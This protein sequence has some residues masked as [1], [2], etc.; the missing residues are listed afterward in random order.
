MC[1]NITMDKKFLEHYNTELRYI[2]EMSGE[3]AKQNPKIAKR[4]ILDEF[5]CKDP[6]VERLLEGFAY[7]TARIQH[8]ID[9]E[10]S[11]FS[12]SLINTIYPQYYNPSPSCAIV[13]FYPDY[14]KSLKLNK[15]VIKAGSLLKSN[16]AGTDGQ[17]CKFRTTSDVVLYPI[18][19]DSLK[20]NI[21]GVEEERLISAKIKATIELRIKS[22][23]GVKLNQTGLDSLRF[24]IRAS[25]L[26]TATM[27]YEQFLANCSGIIFQ[28]P[29]GKRR[30]AEIGTAFVQKHLK[31]VG[32]EEEESLFPI[33]KRT[34]E[35]HRLLREYYLFPKKFMFFDLIGISEAFNKCAGEELSIVF[36]VNKSYNALNN[37]NQTNLCLY[38]APAV[39]L[40]KSSLS[41]V[42][43]DRKNAEFHVPPDKVHPLDYEIIQID[44]VDG[45]N[46]NYTNR[47]EFLPFY[48]DSNF[49]TDRI[50]KKAF[51]NYKRVQRVLTDLEKLHGA[52]TSYIG[53]ELY[54]SLTDMANPPYDTDLDELGIIAWCSNRDLPL[55]M[56]LN[57]NN[58]DFSLDVSPYVTRIECIE[59]PTPPMMP[60][61]VSQWRV[62]N[63][64]SANFFAFLNENNEV[65]IKTL[66][67]LLKLYAITKTDYDVIDNGILSIA[68]KN[69]IRRIES[70]GPILFSRGFS[71]DI[72][73]ND[74]AFSGSN[75]FLL[76]LVLDRFLG[77]S[78]PI[79]SFTETQISSKEMGV[80]ARCPIRTGYRQIL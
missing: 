33:D 62:L 10:L 72:L 43:I 57:D 22:H 27:I 28:S 39:N 65:N 32:F 56:N 71:V 52:R 3:F 64:I 59:G 61:E 58:T 21:G 8:K 15:S 55:I 67:D 50:G 9:S 47:I 20:Y 19:I 60:F 79:N 44:R 73:F 23:G 68:I 78:A 41:R 69:I 5:G 18:S 46:A 2:R 74:M 45:Y 13:Q 70:G 38:C 1:L 54:I 16:P 66:R 12:Q 36:L 51:Y 76:G 80:I 49:K 31:H 4:L 53:T 34:F 6:Y 24:Y 75:F 40:F 11:T 42:S 29:N 30:Y 35:G 48:S 7:M 37:I 26:S 25:E 17:I 77:A 63:N 14:Q